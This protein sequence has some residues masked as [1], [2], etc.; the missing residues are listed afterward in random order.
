MAN[1]VTSRQSAG[2][3]FYTEWN[4]HKVL[5]S[6]PV[7]IFIDFS[8]IFFC[9]NIYSNCVVW[10]RT[11]KKKK[12]FTYN[13]KIQPVWQSNQDVFTQPHLI[14][15]STHWEKKSPFFHGNETNTQQTSPEKWHI[16]YFL[17]DQYFCCRCHV[18]SW[19][20]GFDRWTIFDCFS[21]CSY[22]LGRGR[23][24]NLKIKSLTMLY[25]NWRTKW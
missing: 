16:L 14:N 25:S 9:F 19:R 6:Y 24:G 3:M 17:N 13:R 15:K 22:R 2:S 5:L 7:G 20:F 18:Y 12:Q 1:A 11:E 8:E 23:G 21:T 4:Q 10:R